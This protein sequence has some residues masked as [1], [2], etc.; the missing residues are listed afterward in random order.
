M[1][2]GSPV[3]TVFSGSGSLTDMKGQ[4]LLVYV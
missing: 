1:S 4:C 2:S 3:V